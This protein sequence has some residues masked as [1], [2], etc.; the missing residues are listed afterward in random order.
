MS[1]DRPARSHRFR[2]TLSYIQLK[3]PDTMM[4]FPPRQASAASFALF[5]SLLLLWQPVVQASDQIP[6]KP[7]TQPIAIVGATLFP[8]DAP[9][10]EG[11]TLVFD[12]GK[13]THVGERIDLPDNCQ[14]I[15][16]EG[17]LVYPSI[18][19][20]YSNLGLV[21]INS[22]RATLDESETGDWNPNVRAVAAFNPDSEII[23]VNRANGILLATTAP[24]G[25]ILS[26]RSSLMMLDGWTWEDMA[27]QQDL[28]MHLRWPR[29]QEDVDALNRVMDQAQRYERE[30][31]DSRI[32]DLRL[33]ALVPVLKR[34]M[35]VLVEAD[36]VEA[37][38]AA[39]AWASSR[40]LD[41]I[42][43][44][45]TDAPLCADVLKA[46]QVPV[47]INGV[48]R[49]PRRRHAPY[50]DA[51][52]LPS[53]LQDAG[54][55][56]CIS[57]GGRFGATGIRNLP[58]HAA[59]AAAYGLSEEEALRAITLSPAEILGV[60]DRVGSLTVGKDA[61]LIITDGNVL[62]TPT[63]VEA[64]FIQ[65]RVVDLDNKH[66]QLY[67]KYQAKYAR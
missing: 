22:V 54:I 46:E 67:R 48:Y 16:A 6:G 4:S 66:K 11:G 53:R 30:A 25:G 61:T 57:A 50:D 34:Q 39:V 3:D 37:I 26:G 33:E 23:P 42:L 63:Q 41:L 36:S 18:V 51:Y 45:G 64:A 27:L 35:P 31:A 62:E 19:E 21:E 15:P 10:I 40:Q 65:G 24:S 58:Y 28:G 44:G 1:I 7:Q 5:A 60:D 2:V 9:P 38:Q 12:E 13:I 47:I 49:S 32:R 8:I 20:A 52:A 56:F 43:I 17:K 59:T 55:A 14:T 29:R